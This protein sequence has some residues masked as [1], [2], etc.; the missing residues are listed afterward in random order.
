L[1]QPHET[2]A[3]VSQYFGAS[4]AASSLRW[5]RQTGLMKAVS[6]NPRESKGAVSLLFARSGAKFRLVL[7]LELFHVITI[8]ANAQRADS[9][10]SKER[11]AAHATPSPSSQGVFSQGAY[12]DLKLSYSVRELARLA[13]LSPE[14]TFQ[15]CWGFNFFLMVALMY[16]KGWPLLTAAFEARR[17][18]IRRAIDEAQHLSEDARKR[19]AEV[20]RRWT[21]LDFEIAAIQDRAEAQMKNEEQILRARTAE[22]IRRIMEYS[23]FEIDMAVQRARHELKAVAGDLAVSLAR[24]SIRIDERTDQGLVENF[25]DGLKHHEITQTISQPPARDRERVAGSPRP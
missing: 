16:W 22:D 5:L 3:D 2:G 7:M 17:R 6:R 10:N 11:V 1:Q 9:R 21:H 19:L 20:E 25:I 4:V 23:K 15:L 14:T 18:S 13:G 24:R 8:S 12:A